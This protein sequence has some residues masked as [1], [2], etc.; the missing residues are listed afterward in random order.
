MVSDGVKAELNTV[1][2]I[3]NASVDSEPLESSI[4]TIDLSTA[5]INPGILYRMTVVVTSRNTPTNTGTKTF[6]VAWK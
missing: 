6:N 1:N 3:D 2:D 5:F 4:T